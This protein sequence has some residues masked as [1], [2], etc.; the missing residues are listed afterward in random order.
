[1]AARRHRGATPEAPLTPANCPRRFRVA[2]RAGLTSHRAIRSRRTVMS[3]SPGWVGHVCRSSRSGLAVCAPATRR[4]K[5]GGVA[6]RAGRPKDGPWRRTEIR[7]RWV[8]ELSAGVHVEHDRF[9]ASLGNTTSP[10]NC[11]ARRWM[12]TPRAV[13]A[14]R[15]IHTSASHTIHKGTSAA[16]EDRSSGTMNDEG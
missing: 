8:P 9:E 4:P 16:Q 3:A 7:H 6:E 2:G 13:Q 12:A 15:D 14:R 5:A 1:V 10:S 11:A